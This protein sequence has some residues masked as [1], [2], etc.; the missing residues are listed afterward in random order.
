MAILNQDEQFEIIFTGTSYGYSGIPKSGMPS[1]YWEAM[2]TYEFPA[3]AA[4]TIVEINDNDTNWCRL[5]DGTW[6]NVASNT[7]INGEENTDNYKRYLAAYAKAKYYQDLAITEQIDNGGDSTISTETGTIFAGNVI[8]ASNPDGNYTESIVMYTGEAKDFSSVAQTYTN[9]TFNRIIT[10][11]KAYGAPPQWTEYVDP[12]ILKINYN[13]NAV[14][15]LGRRFAETVV[16]SATVLSLSP[17]I[18]EYNATLTSDDNDYLTAVGDAMEAIDSAMP[19]IRE[20]MEDANGSFISFTP[21]WNKQVVRKNSSSAVENEAGYIAYLNALSK[22]FVIYASR[23]QNYEN[24]MND[25][26]GGNGGVP[27]S[28]RIVPGIGCKYSD[29]DWEKID[30]I[31]NVPMSANSS[32]SEKFTYVNFFASGQNQI[33]EEFETSV[34]STTIEDQINGSVSG[35]L[36]DVA[37]LTGGIIGQGLIESDVQHLISETGNSVGGMLGNI[38]AGGTEMLKGGK[39]MFPQIIDDCTFGKST[40]FT[41]RFTSP[42]GDIE[43]IIWNNIF[44]YIHFLP[45]VIPRQVETAVEMYSYPFLCRAFAKGIYNC[46]VGVL[47]NFRIQRAGQDDT[48]WSCEGLPREIEVQFDI[49]P[50]YAKMSMSHFEGSRSTAYA[51]KNSGLQEYIA[52]LTG[53]DLRLGEVDLKLA[54]LASLAKGWLMDIPERVALWAYSI[55]GASDIVRWGKEVLSGIDALSGDSNF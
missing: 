52:T 29:I 21:A 44:G 20:S 22:L 30:G 19:D 35:A 27:L 39:I 28:S 42:S 6:I 55:S 5:E 43:S 13:G 10:A 48:L 14:I 50:L 9:R 25:E 1:E 38:L 17:G 34:R 37:F 47:K 7:S 40:T 18:V 16:S 24:N 45:F 2:K 46:P 32:R 36:K 8:R 23:T 54:T 51:I 11:I 12:R 41:I 49:T 15:E 3:N 33:S 31:D 4:I 53:V 26:T